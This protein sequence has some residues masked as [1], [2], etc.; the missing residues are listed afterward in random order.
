M[1]NFKLVNYPVKVKIIHVLKR[2]AGPRPVLA[3]VVC[4]ELPLGLVTRI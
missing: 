2:L 3:D 1:H 4:S